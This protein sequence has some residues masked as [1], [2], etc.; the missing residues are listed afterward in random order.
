MELSLIRSFRKDL[1]RLEREVGRKLKDDTECCG[2]TVSQC[3]VILEIGNKGEMS[4]VDLAGILNVDTSTLSRNI[5]NMVNLELVNRVTNPN[6]R[7]YVF[8]ALTAKGKQVYESIEDMCN[9][10]YNRVFSH[11]APELHTQ[12]IEAFK[13][14]V[15]AILKA[16]QDEDCGCCGASRD[17]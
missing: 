9:Q 8:V 4:I 15:S 7:R 14:I 12:V 5:N 17:T 10:Y 2:V 3:H 1:R 16:N 13:L 11:I 6:D